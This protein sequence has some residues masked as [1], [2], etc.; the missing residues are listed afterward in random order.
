MK[1][2]KFTVRCGDFCGVTPLSAASVQAY[3]PLVQDK[4]AAAQVGD[5]NWNWGKNILCPTFE[6]SLANTLDLLYYPAVH[7]PKHR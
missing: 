5:R 2:R 6:V 4:A 1:F 3:S 7:K